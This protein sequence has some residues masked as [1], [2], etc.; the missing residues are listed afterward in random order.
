VSQKHDKLTCTEHPHFFSRPDQI[1]EPL[2][3]LMP[4]MNPIRYRTRWKLFSDAVRRFEANGGLVYVV[5][6][7]FGEREFCVT[8]PANPRHLRIHTDH[9][10]WH[11][12]NALNLLMKRL[13]LDWKY[14]AWIDGDVSFARDDIFNETL[15][16]LQHY[17]VVQMWSQAQDLDPHHQVIQSHQSFVY[18]WTHG[19]PYQGDACYPYGKRQK[20][21]TWHPGFAWAAR[22]EAID[23]VGGLIDFCILGSADNHM[24][25]ALIG[26]VERT[27]IPELGERYKYMLRRWEEYAEKHIKR[28][29]GYVPGLVLHE[30]HGPKVSRR[31]QDRWKIL[32]E[33]VFDPDTDLKPD[34]QGLYQ[35][36]D[37]SKELRDR[38]R[39]YFRQRNEDD[40]SVE[41]AWVNTMRGERK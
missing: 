38:L 17:Q 30:W 4:I 7:Q 2:H 24:A 36:T 3:I 27:L 37:R 33:T 29:I 25:S 41:S 10:I 31:Y 16:Q 39:A 15:H 35:L 20:V 18:C 12:E 19:I 11:K 9:E 23:A 14:L 32:T 8:D 40:V 34:W 26:E 6:V 21:V 1:N 28:N 22:R 13:P 5:E